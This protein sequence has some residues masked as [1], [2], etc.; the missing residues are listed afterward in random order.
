MSKIKDEIRSQIEEWD[1]FAEL[2]Q[3]LEG[4][5]LTINREI[6]D[7][8][9]RLFTYEDSSIHR[10]FF[11]I[12]NASLGEYHAQEEIGLN[13]FCQ[14]DYITSDLAELKRMLND[15]MATAFNSRIVTIFA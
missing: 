15:G 10:K 14:I 1:Y 4:F 6:V 11:V 8:F 7:G 12:Y 3:E 5:H 13:L 2:P 9:Y